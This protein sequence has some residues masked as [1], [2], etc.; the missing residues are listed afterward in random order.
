MREIGDFELR[1]F[2]NPGEFRV[3]EA[4]IKPLLTRA[5]LRIGVSGA[6]LSRVQFG[7]I[8]VR[9]N[10]AISDQ[11]DAESLKQLFYEFFE[12]LPPISL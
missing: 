8:I 5:S 9:L 10:P 4:D 1:F 6:D 3:T 7:E 2:F 12:K 11:R